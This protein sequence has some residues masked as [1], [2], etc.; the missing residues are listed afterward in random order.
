MTAPL[1]AEYFDG[2]STRVRAVV[3]SVEDGRLLVAG[4]GIELSIP[5]TAVRVDE[6]LGNSPRR[7]RLPGGAFCVVRDLNRLASLLAAAGHREGRVD[8]LQRGWKIAI[9]AGAGCILLALAFYQWGLP[10]VAA[11]GARRMPDTVGKS[12]AQ[13]TLKALDRNLTQPSQLSEDRQAELRA[14]FLALHLPDGGTPHSALLFRKSPALGANAFTLPDGTVIL[15]D[16]LVQSLKDDELILAV[17]AHE[18]GHA[19]GR[20]GLQLLIQTSVVGAFWAFYIGDVSTLFAAAPTALMQMKFSRGLET[21][22]DDYGARLL[23]ANG[24][25][26]ALLADALQAL[27]AQRKGKDEIPYLANHPPT[28]DRIEALRGQRR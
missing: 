12:L 16:D 5:F 2:R 27:E 4:A 11:E 17:T 14:K 6:R 8:L 25:K 22:A 3:L 9:A 19:H 1:D 20:H 10:W 24:L 26:P 23:A 28:E 13:Q 21:Q 7:L 15:L 18:L